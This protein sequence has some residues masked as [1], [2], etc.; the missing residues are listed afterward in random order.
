ML[1]KCIFIYIHLKRS[2]IAVAILGGLLIV[3]YSF[4]SDAA[5][6]DGIGKILP[7]LNSCCF[8]FTIFRSRT[9]EPSN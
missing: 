1:Y 3:A 6:T 4:A 9:V 2:L 5:V 7:E 8:Y